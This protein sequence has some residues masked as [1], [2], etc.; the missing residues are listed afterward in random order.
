[1]NGPHDPPGGWPDRYGNPDT[2]WDEFHK[3]ETET[4]TESEDVDGP[5]PDQDDEVD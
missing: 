5:V 2:Y 4:E 1:M 3:P